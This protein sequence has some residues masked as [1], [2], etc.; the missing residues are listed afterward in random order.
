L[1]GL[2]FGFGQFLL[3]RAFS[4]ADAGVLA[5][6]TYVQIVAAI[7]FGAMVFGDLPDTWTLTGTS[8]IIVSGLYVLRRQAA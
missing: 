3:I 4:M 6:F 2:L 1:S 8:L 5:P 7:V